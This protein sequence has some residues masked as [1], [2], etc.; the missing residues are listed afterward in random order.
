MINHGLSTGALFL[1]V[2]MFYDRYHTRDINK[3]S[4]L[5]KRMPVFATFFIF[6][7]LASIGLPGLNGFVSEFLTILGA[8]TS[9][10]L[11]VEFG[12]VAAL[13]IILGAVYM[14]HMAAKIIW[15]PLKTPDAHGEHGDHGTPGDIGAREIAI[16][17]PLALA[18]IYIG[19][20]PSAIL[21]SMKDPLEAIR[22]PIAGETQ[23]AHVVDHTSH[24]TLAAIK[25]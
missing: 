13:G 18:I 12:T 9:P 4:G 20:Y 2:G 21:R 7:T 25:P 10:Y 14:L 22:A 6:F 11:G 15:G 24:T 16:L 1:C 8:F 5:A 3:L 19:V 17:V 23:T